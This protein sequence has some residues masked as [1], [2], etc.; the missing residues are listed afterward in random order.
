MD[1][2]EEEIKKLRTFVEKVAAVGRD[3]NYNQQ[4]LNVFNNFIEESKSLLRETFKPVVGNMYAFYKRSESDRPSFRILDL[5]GQNGVEYL[6]SNHWFNE[7]RE[8]TDAEAKLLLPYVFKDCHSVNNP[9]QHGVDLVQM[10]V[11]LCEEAFS[12]IDN[13]NVTNGYYRT[14][15][16][17]IGLELAVRSKENKK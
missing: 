17:N 6:A 10:A 1:T 8:L 15:A 13:E 11:S 5:I 9:E 12:D 4:D 16:E 7:Y 3:F 2:V 14:C